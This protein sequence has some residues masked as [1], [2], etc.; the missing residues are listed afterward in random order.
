MADWDDFVADW[1]RRRE[2]FTMAEVSRITETQGYASA[3][4]QFR[5]NASHRVVDMQLDRARREANGKG[6]GA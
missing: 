1:A 4:R 2:L 6:R 3:R 5:L